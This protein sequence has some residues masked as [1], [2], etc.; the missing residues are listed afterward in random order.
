MLY[1][2]IAESAFMDTI[3][4]HVHTCLYFVIIDHDMTFFHLLHAIF[5]HS[6]HLRVIQQQNTI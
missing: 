6:C 5:I 1:A 3:C 4:P 2:Y